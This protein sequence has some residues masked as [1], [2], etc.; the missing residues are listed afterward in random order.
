M[1]K[2][3]RQVKQKRGFADGYNNTVAK[4]A[5]RRGVAAQPIAPSATPDNRYH[6]ALPS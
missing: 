5:L 1:M 4:D 6:Y 2:L 3:R